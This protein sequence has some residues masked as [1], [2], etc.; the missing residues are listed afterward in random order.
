MNTAG[1]LTGC[2]GRQ[3][4]ILVRFA[5]VLMETE[6]GIINGE[7]MYLSLCPIDIR[8][9]IPVLTGFMV[10]SLPC[11]LKEARSQPEDI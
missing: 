3:D 6:I 1:T 9:Y 5:K 11:Y 10:D 8:T 2:G 4:L 7:V